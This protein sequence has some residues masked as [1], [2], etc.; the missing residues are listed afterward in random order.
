MNKFIGLISKVV[1]ATALVGT[2]T[3]CNRIPLLGRNQSANQTGNSPTAAQ[4]QSGTRTRVQRA[5]QPTRQAQ[6]TTQTNAQ[7]PDG[8][9]NPEASNTGSGQSDS[10][11]GVS[12]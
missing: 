1:V 7:S 3:G 5:N 9:I 4:N 11:Q 8:T 12:A 10:N 6:N 2:V